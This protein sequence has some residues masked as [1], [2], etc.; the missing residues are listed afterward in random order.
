MALR[1]SIAVE[2]GLFRAHNNLG[3]ALLKTGHL[4]EAIEHYKKALQLRPNSP[5]PYGN[6]ALTYA[7]MNRPADAIV[8]A[9]KALELAR[10]QSNTVLAERIDDWLRTYRAHQNLPNSTP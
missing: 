4:Q 7:Q 6:L 2:A 10:S 8:S 3:N 5:E 9:E 1:A